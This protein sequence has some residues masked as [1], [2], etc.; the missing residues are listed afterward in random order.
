MSGCWMVTITGREHFLSGAEV[1]TNLIDI[2][3]VA[4]ALSQINRFV[5][6]AMRP[7]SVAE[8]SLFVAEIAARDGKTPLVQLAC[9]L[10]DAHEAF[11]NDVS[12]PA[13]NAIGLQ[14]GRF[15]ALQA[16]RVRRA[17]GVE[18]AFAKHQS[19][20][21]HFDLVAL[22]TERQQLTNYNPRH[23]APWPVI[24]TVGAQVRPCAWANLTAGPSRRG[25]KEW[26]DAFLLRYFDLCRAVQADGDELS[27]QA[28]GAVQ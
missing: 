9:L 5:G 21:C 6:H 20:I 23:H 14:W 18:A 16:D 15:E 2:Y 3:D 25:W 26:R 1:Q 13:K 19:M 11:T 27:P 22:A 8:H 4:W 28:Q 7:Y 24:D 10:H 12:S 17:L